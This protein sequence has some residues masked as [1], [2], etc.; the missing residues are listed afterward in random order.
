VKTESNQSSSSGIGFCGALAVLF[1][2]L[3][4]T[5][6]IYWSWWF[7]LAPIWG[8]LVFAVLIIIAM[9]IAAAIAD[10]RDDP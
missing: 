10:R 8:P 2:A 3:K 9:S 7:V 4:L 6:Y 1:I 5:G